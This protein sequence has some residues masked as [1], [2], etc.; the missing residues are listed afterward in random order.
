MRDLMDIT[1]REAFD[2]DLM[3]EVPDITF[4]TV[5]ATFNRLRQDADLI[6]KRG[7]A[8][9]F[10]KLDRRFKSHDGFKIGSRIILTHVFDD[11]GSW[12]YHGR[13][14]DTIVDVE[15]VFA[16][17][18]NHNPTPGSL[19]SAI[20][21]S[22]GSGLN[23][24]QSD[25]EASYFRIKGFMNGNAHIWFMRDDLV[26]KANK[27][28]ADY[29]GAALGDAMDANATTEDLR[30]DIGLPA[31]TL[32]FFPTPEAVIEDMMINAYLRPGQSVL[33]PS[34]GTGN[35]ARAALPRV[36]MSTPSKSIPIAS[37]RSRPLTMRT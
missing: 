24:R 29:Y 32:A 37:A 9:A 22:R 30:T 27:L 6:F 4:E 34:A 21:R 12:N 8:T 3:G 33:E 35:I 13:A 36:R 26:Q 7:L 17:L 31:K 23:P 2:R 28:L 10:S 25:C 18:D 20:E 19:I 14:R 5:T 1:D 16:I 15:R 11:W